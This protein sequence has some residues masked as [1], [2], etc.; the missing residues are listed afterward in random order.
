MITL[1]SYPGLFGLED[2]NP[3]GLKVFAFLKLSGLPFEHRHV[4]DTSAAPRGQLPY[5]V[6]DD[7]T[8]GDSDSIIAH[9]KQRYTL[10]LDDPLTPPQHDLD[11]LVRRTLD[12][13]Y[14][15]MSYSRWRDD[16]YWPLFRAAL[17]AALPDADP[18]VLEHARQYNFERYRYQG[19]GRYEPDDAYARGIGDLQAVT[20]LLADGP[21]MFGAAPASIDAAVYGF[22]ANIL[23]YDIDTPLK[24]FV[25]AQAQL[26]EHC[27]A[28]RERMGQRRSP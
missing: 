1:Y 7:A 10:T 23:F 15:V 20:N 8:I 14:W 2:N 26:V 13:L 25:V 12:D 24:R 5:L 3:F 9:L 17:L 18:D 28:M 27:H 11:L 4:I 6:D 19:I 22:V 16:R 21:F